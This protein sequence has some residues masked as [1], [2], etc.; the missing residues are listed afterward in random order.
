MEK[1]RL[2]RPEKRHEK[3]ALEYLEEI[4]KH[5]SEFHGL[6]GLDRYRNDYDGWLKKLAADRVCTPNETRVPAETFFLVK[7]VPGVSRFDG[8]PFSTENKI[9]GMVNIR[10]ALNDALWQENGNI[11]YSI[12]PSERRKG[13]AKLQLYLALKVCQEHG[14]EVAFLDCAEENVG[15]SKTI[16]VLGGRLARKR[17]CPHYTMPNKYVAVTYFVIDVDAAVEKYAEQYDQ[18]IAKDLAD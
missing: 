12:R 3:Q 2:A 13:Y 6:G 1:F 10:L 17:V 4:M 7:E 9:V 5:D 14:I 8:M 11:G 18:F 16:R 15:S